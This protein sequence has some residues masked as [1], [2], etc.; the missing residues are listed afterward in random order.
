MRKKA[1][2]PDLPINQ[3]T[4]ED[5][6][7]YT[8]RIVVLRRSSLR[9]PFASGD[10]RLYVTGGFGAKAGRIGNAVFG[11]LLVDGEEARWDRVDIQG[12]AVDQNHTEAL[13]KV[14]RSW[15]KL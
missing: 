6:Q 12:M 7:D 13:N 15:G 11:V 2:V 10:R 5:V 8:G 1:E 4:T 14:L 3:Y 9:E